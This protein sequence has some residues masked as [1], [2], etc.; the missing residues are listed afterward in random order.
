MDFGFMRAS[1][2]D[3]SRPNK[4]EDRIVESFDGYSSYL[5]VV[6]EC[7]RFI[8]VFLCR[9]KEPPIEEASAFLATFGLSTGGMIRC[10]QGG[11]LARSKDFVTAMQE[12]HQYSVE[13]TGADSPSQNGMAENKNGTLAILTRTLLYGAALH[14]KYWSAALLH[15]VW[16]HNRRVHSATKRTPFEGHYGK[17]PNL[18]QLKL[19]GSRVCVKRPGKRRA[20]LDRHDFTGIFLGYTASDS[21]IRYIDLNTG[22]VKTSHH[23]VF[24]EAWYLHPNR[25][26]AAQLL[27][28]LG[29]VNEDGFTSPPATEEERFAAYPSIP[30]V[31]KPLPKLPL[32]AKSFPLPLRLTADPPSTAARAANLATVDPYLD[33]CLQ[34]NNRDGQAV[35]DYFI[36]RRDWAQIYASPHAYHDGFDIELPLLRYK[37]DDPTAGMRF[38]FVNGRLILDRIEKSTIAAKIPRWR[39]RL[40]GAWL[41]KIGD[42]EVD[43]VADVKRELAKCLGSNAPACWLTFSHPAIKHGLTNDGIPQINVDQLNPRHLFANAPVEELN[44]AQ[45]PSFPLPDIGAPAAAA[46]SVQT[47]DDGGGNQRNQRRQ[48]T[49]TWQ[50]STG[51]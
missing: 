41:R 18:Q 31:A 23:A 10:D 48:S 27:Y 17:K 2:A 37:K 26:P 1:T 16:L 36:T 47:L 9:S 40:R 28:D 25:P 51:R 4:E 15:A 24:D 44:T 12:R 43:S 39:S 33:T 35:D 34:T 6:D 21:N 3:F 45:P 14:A 46:A 8:W 42:V 30:D 49:H 19:F 5:I 22:N 38:R 32:N 29:V 20:K 7:S 13:P 50:T 11:E